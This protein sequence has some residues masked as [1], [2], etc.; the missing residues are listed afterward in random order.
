MKK[1]WSEIERHYERLKSRE[2]FDLSI[3]CVVIDQNVEVMETTLSGLA[4]HLRVSS[5]MSNPLVKRYIG[6]A[7]QIGAERA[8]NTLLMD[9]DGEEFASLWTEAKSDV[10]KG[11]IATMDDLVAAI[12][13]AKKGF[14]EKTRRIL[15]VQINA[16]DADVLLVG[17]P[18]ADDFG[19]R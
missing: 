11:C 16:K 1:N 4:N 5:A 6:L 14:N 15:V 18:S 3:P 2:K 7:N 13:C 10:E 9:D 17:P 12:K 19:L 8:M